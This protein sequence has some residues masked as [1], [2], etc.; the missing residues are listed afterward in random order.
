MS[1]AVR[2]TCPI[3]WGATNNVKF[4]ML[5]PKDSSGTQL[6]VTTTMIPLTSTAESSL[7]EL[8]EVNLNALNLRTL[9]GCDTMLKFKCCTSGFPPVVDGGTAALRM[10][11]S[12]GSGESVPLSPIY[13]NVSIA[14]LLTHSCASSAFRDLAP[15]LL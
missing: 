15:P 11:T 6:Q 5:I 12:A 14:G 3:T 1:I 9:T 7:T 4:Q 2:K 8:M 13:L 10:K